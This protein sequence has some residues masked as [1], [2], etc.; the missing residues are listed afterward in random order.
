MARDRLI[1]YAALSVAAAVATIALKGAAYKLTGSV[2]LLSDALESL[3]NLASA[4]MAMAMLAVAAR[5]ADDGHN[6]GHDKAEYF[7]SALEGVAILGAAALI[8]WAALPRL[9]DPQPIE[10][11][12]L[13][14]A[15][16]SGASLINL[17][18]SRVLMRAGCAHESVTLQADAHHLM[19][20]VWT[21]VGIIAGVVLVQLTGWLWLDPL[22]ALA[23]AAHIAWTGLKIIGVAVDGLMDA[24][25]PAPEQAAVQALLDRYKHEHG[26][27]WHALRTR[28]AGSRRFASVHIL[29][30]GDW[31]VQRA[32]DLAE[33]I[34]RDMGH[35]LKR[36]HVITHLEPLEDAASWR[37]TALDREEPAS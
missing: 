3:V 22:I 33:R 10:Q 32:H 20:D 13:G 35:T 31:S 2:G 29:V 34:E 9:L 27:E 28:A 36:L 23:V 7:S 25:L 11:A 26:I 8:A 30:P 21:S 18:V 17:A 4:L 16:S 5:P 37:D 15:I 1:R 14:L 24:A 6:F 12:W 19:T